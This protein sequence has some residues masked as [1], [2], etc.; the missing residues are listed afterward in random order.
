MKIY[1]HFHPEDNDPVMSGKNAAETVEN[2]V[3][4]E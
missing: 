4:V 3:T 1:K 2:D